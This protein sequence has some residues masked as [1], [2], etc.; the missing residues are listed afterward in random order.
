MRRRRS[1]SLAFSSFLDP[2]IMFVSGRDIGK[3]CRLG[4]IGQRRNLQFYLLDPKR[5]TQAVNEVGWR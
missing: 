4:E 2:E 1:C 5:Q 3:I